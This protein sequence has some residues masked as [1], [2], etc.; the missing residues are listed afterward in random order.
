MERSGRPTT[1]F[2]LAVA[3]AISVHGQTT[4][5]AAYEVDGKIQLRLHNSNGDVW[6]D[7]RGEFKVFV[8]GPGG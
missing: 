2:A 8:N 7:F 1:A 5:E 3:L 6:K 4:P